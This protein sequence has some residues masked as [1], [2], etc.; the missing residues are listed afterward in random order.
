MRC[1]MTLQN[2]ELSHKALKR[3]SA[4]DA[5]RAALE[6]KTREFIRNGGVIK[7]IESGVSAIR[8]VYSQKEIGAHTFIKAQE[9]KAAV[10][11]KPLNPETMSARKIDITGRRF[12]RLVVL[13]LSD[14][15]YRSRERMWN[16][17]CDCGEHEETTTFR[18]T[19]G[20]KHQCR[21]CA[22]G[23]IKK[24]KTDIYNATN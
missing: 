15:M 18:L 11:R 8:D 4:N 1:I 23:S 24:R 16:I 9:R 12:S 17:V 22:K 21:K 20:V 19:S 2:D 10:S 5:A 13:G 7:K 3:P 6:E 14:N